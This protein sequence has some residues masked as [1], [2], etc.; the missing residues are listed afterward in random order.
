MREQQ[1]QELTMSRRRRRRRRTEG[2]GGA[3]SASASAS[4][5]AAAPR[6]A[7]SL[8]ATYLTT[9]LAALLAALGRA[10]DDLAALLVSLPR[11]FRSLSWAVRAGLAYRALFARAERQALSPDARRRALSALHSAAAARLVRV[12]RANG[13]VYIKFAQFASSLQQVAPEYRAHLAQLQDRARPRPFRTVERVLRRELG[14]PLERVF[15]EFCPEAAAAASL[16]QVH[17]ARLACGTEVAVKVQYAGLAGAARADLATLD[18]LALLAAFAFPGQARLGWLCAEMRRK[19]FEELD[20]GVEVANARRLV[21]LQRAAAAEEEEEEEQERRRRGHEEGEDDEENGGGGGGSSSSSSWSPLVV[22]PR[23]YEHL[24][25]P[26]V[27][28]MEWV[29]GVKVS[30]AEA[31]RRAR[32]SPRAVARRVEAAFSEMVFSLGWVHADPHPGNIIVRPLLPVQT[33]GGRRHHHHHH[34]RHHHHHQQRLQQGSGRGSGSGGGGSL[35]PPALAA[36]GARSPRGLALRS[37][38]SRFGSTGSLASLGGASGGGS[39]RKSSSVAASPPSSSPPPPNHRRQHHRPGLLHWLREGSWTPFEVVL[40]DHGSYLRVPP[41]LRRNYAALWC[42]LAAGD[43]VGASRASIAMAGQRA[44]QILPVVL[45]QRARTAAERDRVHEAAGVGGF[46]D[47][48][49]LLQAAPRD[50]VEVLRVTSVVRSVTAPLG[51][52]NAARAMVNGAF[53]LRSMSAGRLEAMGVGTGD[54]A[55]GGGGV[56]GGS[57]AASAEGSVVA[58]AAGE[59]EA[60]AASAASSSSAS[61]SASSESAAAP[62]LAE[63]EEAKQQLDV[64]VTTRPAPPIEILCGPPS[65]SSSGGATAAEVAA[66]PRASA[67]AA[68][69]SHPL[70]LVDALAAVGKQEEAEDDDDDGGSSVLSYAPSSSS[71]WEEEE[72]EEQERE[73]RRPSGTDAADGD[74]DNAENDDDPLLRLLLRSRAKAVAA[75]SSRHHHRHHQPPASLR[76]RLFRARLA[77]R[78]RLAQVGSGA[79]AALERVLLAGLFLFGQDVELF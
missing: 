57:A 9:L 40:L 34:R 32:V 29:H 24:C 19:L 35:G 69:A 43:R 22:V 56:A 8:L 7:A 79:R 39:R 59:G 44:G 72:A 55:G 13:G 63:L 58:V 36:F 53:A 12:C 46:A 73:R 33:S 5:P 67:A 74:T 62:S 25:T 30:D 48:A 61:S 17:R 23:F 4:A 54:A 18:A 31:L 77:M 65:S 11:A 50:V 52:P 42:A 37:S 2:T 71:G 21:A 47:V 14:Q 41:T 10:L 3:S 28:V 64:V 68:L 51:F 6:L 15:P 16:A 26:K 38:A 75:S 66:P 78:L 49:D 60:A 20:F 70:L 45:T 1:Q 27:L 76:A